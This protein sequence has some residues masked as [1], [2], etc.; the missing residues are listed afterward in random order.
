MDAILKQKMWTIE[1][2]A[3]TDSGRMRF[4]MTSGAV[5]RDGEIVDPDGMVADAFMAN[6]VFLYGHDSYAPPLGIITSLQRTGAGWEAEVD[7]A[8]AINPFAAMIKAYYEAGMMR[9]VSIRFMP[10]E[11]ENGDTDK[12]GYHTKFTKWELL[13]LSAVT[14]PANPE[15]LRV[16][17]VA[18][19]PVRQWLKSIQAAMDTP[20][21][22]AE[23][24]QAP[25]NDPAAG[26]R[27]DAG[28][29]SYP[30]FTVDY[31]MDNGLYSFNVEARD[32]D[33]AEK[34]LAAIKDT[35]V[36]SGELVG[37]VPCGDVDDDDDDEAQGGAKGTDDGRDKAAGDDAAEGTPGAEPGAE[38]KT[39]DSGI[40]L[41]NLVGAGEGIT[42]TEQEL[43][44]T[45]ARA[46]AARLA[47]LE[48]ER[49]SADEDYLSGRAAI[50]HLLA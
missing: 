25:A 34:R 18:G 16:R 15:A 48:T 21:N 10:K 43:A 11:W 47:A 24:A 36:V 19:G 5:D 26:E 46:V 23:S 40:T 38:S 50:R 45:V 2:Q 33:E 30:M 1:R 8:D 6:P 37:E 27:K 14:I 4:L 42:I 3:D 17:G 32:W 28:S 35:A 29:S 41:A 20:E 9:A 7:W 39:D 44:E 22:K 49:K 12:D 13:E 31:A